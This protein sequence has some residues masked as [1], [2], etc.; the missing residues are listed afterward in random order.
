[1]SHQKE[2]V[3][4]ESTQIPRKAEGDRRKSFESKELELHHKKAKRST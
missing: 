4:W 1:M 3:N 2:Q